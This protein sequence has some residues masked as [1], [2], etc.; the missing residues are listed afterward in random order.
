MMW[1]PDITTQ[2]EINDLVEVLFTTAPEVMGID[3]VIAGCQV[4]DLD[5]F[6]VGVGTVP[7]YIRVALR[8]QYYQNVY[9]RGGITGLAVTDYVTVIHLRDGNR[10][11]VLG[12]GGST[13]GVPNPPPTPANQGEAIVSDAALQWTATLTPTWLGSHTFDAGLTV[14]AG[15]GITLPDPGWIGLGPASPRLTM[16]SGVPNVAT[17]DDFGNVG[18]E[19][20]LF[21]IGDT[22]TY[23][24]FSPDF[25]GFRVGNVDMLQMDENG[26]DIVEV[27]PTGADV[28]FNV[29]AVGVADA[30]SVDGATG[31][32]T[33]GALGAGIV[34]STAGGVLSSDY[35]IDSTLTMDGGDILPVDADGQALGDETHLWDLYTQEIVFN[36]PSSFNIVHVP[37]NL[38][39]ALHLSDV[40]GIEYLKIVTTDTQPIIRFNDGA[41]DIDFEIEAIGVPDALRVQ[42]SDGQITLGALTAG[43]VQS[44]AGGVLSSD[45]TIDST[46]TMASGEDI[47]PIDASGQA[48]GDATHR[49]DLYTQE[50]VFGGT[51]GANSITVPN[52]LADALHLSDAG[53]LEYWRIV[54]S[55]PPAQPAVV[56]NEGGA[57]I[58]FRIESA[59]STHALWVKGSDGAVGI[60][61]TGATIAALLHIRR[62]GITSVYFDG[63]NAGN[64]NVGFQFRKFGDE[65]NN[66][67]LFNRYFATHTVYP[68]TFAILHRV[69][70]ATVGSFFIQADGDF[71]LDGK[72]V[73]VGTAGPGGKCEIDQSSATGAIPVLVL[74]QADVDQ[75]FIEFQSATLYTGKT[76]QDEYVMVKNQAGNVRYL[77]LY[78]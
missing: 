38:A 57:D 33:L 68:D 50:V 11:E 36:G 55:D 42:G 75:P 58:D 45:Y 64:D 32:V 76:A 44:T 43:I 66:R 10:Y 6:G 54:S 8:D 74:D 71:I 24:V 15:Q 1:E 52:D 20:I 53:G 19:N 60:G 17:F 22:D 73:G 13:G 69:G 67:T 34:Q 16:T 27:N 30:L 65:A 47:L 7:R 5:P 31:Q 61:A 25:C 49:W 23:M 62:Q 35:V 56:F 70:G 9:Y 40:G 12:P 14:G 39:D 26:V 3:E 21:H 63:Y 77:R 28:D 18:I 41:A 29:Q 51:T 78:A 48:L 46:L 59:V 37:D 2:Q 72:N 4:I